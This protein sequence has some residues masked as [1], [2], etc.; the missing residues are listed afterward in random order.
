MATVQTCEN[1][2][3]RELVRYELRSDRPLYAVCPNC[4]L[5]LMLDTR[6]GEGALVE[7]SH[8]NL[9]PLRSSRRRPAQ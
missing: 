8:G 5:M 9:E 6:R 1:C 7:S 2:G 4:E 3:F